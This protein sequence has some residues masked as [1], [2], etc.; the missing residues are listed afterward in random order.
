MVSL[1]HMIHIR[2]STHLST[3]LLWKHA[4]CTL[5]KRVVFKSLL[6]ANCESKWKR[7]RM[8]FCHPLFFPNVIIHLWYCNFMYLYTHG[9]SISTSLASK[10]RCYLAK[11]R[12]IENS[13][14][15]LKGLSQW[16]LC[17]VSLATLWNVN[18]KWAQSWN[19]LKF[20]CHVIHLHVTWHGG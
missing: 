19:S 5:Y 8:L 20:E 3:C 6:I 15:P 14:N 2:A 13:K 11:R 7:W 9:L 18:S 12:L 17:G 16:N 10:L 4:L 1:F